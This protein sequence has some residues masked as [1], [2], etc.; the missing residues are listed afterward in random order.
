MPFIRIKKISNK[1]YAY[2]VENT[3]KK[4]KKASRQKSLKYLGRVFEIEKSK[5]NP[6]IFNNNESFQE[7]LIRVI[8]N[9]IVNFEF[10]NKENIF[11]K[12]NFVIDFEKKKVFS[13][14]N[15]KG[16]SLKLN[17]GFLNS[18][19]LSCLINY[20]PKGDSNQIAFNLANS[21]V[22]AGIHVEKEDFIEL[23]SKLINE[24]GLNFD[25]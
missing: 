17:D 16:I 19:T 14:K 12:D 15:N 23:Y 1:N 11:I 10:E 20:Q 4:R 24:H 25:I 13:N 8:K 9:E 2:L 5:Q 6:F 3:W 18:Y 22:V 21:F 7:N